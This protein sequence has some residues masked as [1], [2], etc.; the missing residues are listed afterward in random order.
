MST[1]R[2]K[3]HYRRLDRSQNNFPSETF[4]SVVAKALEHKTVSGERALSRVADR[5]TQSPTNAEHK[6]FLNHS[7]NEG[8]RD[9]VFGSVCLFSPGD[10]QALLELDEKEE[11][12]SLAEALRAWNIAEIKAPDG[13]EYLHAITYWM[14][15]GDHFYQIQH[16]S[17][18]AKAME[19]YF[20]WLLREKTSMISS[21]HHVTLQWEF[22]RAQ[23][24]EDLGDIK[25]VEI[26]GFVPE[27]SGDKVETQNGFG[28]VVEFE[29]HESMGDRM[30][31]N[32]Q[33]GRKILE[34]LLGDVGA[35][36]IIDSIPPQAAL[37]VKVSFGYRAKKR[38]IEKEF[39]ANL[40]TGLRHI[41]DGEI[42]VRGRDGLIKGNDARLSADMNIKRQG[43]ASSLL[44]LEDVL[45]QMTEVHR[46]F[47]HD[48]HITN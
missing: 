1:R 8:A 42:R 29:S 47:L 5:V 31:Q 21:S 37:E 48:G 22:D 16:A 36:K 41:A 19:E 46:R 43:P 11:H 39:M 32:F 14:I 10:M 15:I 2:C 7:Y 30:A 6:R 25:T 38:K 13:K 20:T 17:L 34:D 44:D 9:L 45:K 35:K 33:K 3:I 26:G 40:A 4:A 12:G 18:P 28:K 24:G 27:T 23:V